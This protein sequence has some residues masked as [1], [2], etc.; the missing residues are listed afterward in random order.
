MKIVK[1]KEIIAKDISEIPE[2]DEFAIFKDRNKKL[3]NMPPPFFVYILD[4]AWDAF[5]SHGDYNYKK[6]NAEAQG[7]FV[8]HYYEDK[9]GKFVVATKYEEGYGISQSAYVEMSDEC[10]AG[11]SA[12]CQKDDIL[13]LI[14]VHTHPGF[15]VWYSQ[16]DKNNLKSNFYM[17]YQIGIVVDILNKTHKGFKIEGTN[18][19]EFVN[20]RIFD[21]QTQKLFLPY[22]YSRHI[23]PKTNAE[24]EKI[25]KR[26]LKGGT[27][28]SAFSPT[29][30]HVSNSDSQNQSSNV[31]DYKG[32][33]VIA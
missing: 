10:L 6:F 20:Y 16:P 2:D 28:Q 31:N 27:K 29:M 22:E 32:V 33:D 8:G 17:S 25:T 12:R 4:E 11:I 21:K 26:E 30:S 14:H 24:T 15:N 9:I 5:I 18:V 1:T 7:V 3:H 23:S 19:V 13:M